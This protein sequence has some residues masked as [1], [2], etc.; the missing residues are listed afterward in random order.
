MLLILI[1]A[2]YFIDWGTTDELELEEN[3]IGVGK[4]NGVYIIKGENYYVVAGTSIKSKRKAV[5]EFL[6]LVERNK[7][8]PPGMY[9]KMSK[10]SLENLRS[11]DLMKT[12]DKNNFIS[13]NKEERVV[14]RVEDKRVQDNRSNVNNHKEPIRER[15]MKDRRN[16]FYHDR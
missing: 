13:S 16:N 5:R 1:V 10:T 3:I 11:K 8:L 15:R 4:A 6:K 14:E 2:V 12:L 9:F 7:L